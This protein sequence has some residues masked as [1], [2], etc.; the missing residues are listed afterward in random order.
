MYFKMRPRRLDALLSHMPGRVLILFAHPAP[1][2]SRINR[3]LIASVRGL[4]NVTINDLYEEYP[5]FDINVRREQELLL[6]H[7]IIVFQHPFYWYSSPAILKEWEDLVLEY[8]FAY[9][10]GGTKL[11]GKLFLTA[12]TTGG[13]REAYRRAGFNFFTIREL[14]A[15]FEQSAKFCGMRYLPPFVIHGARQFKDESEIIAQVQAYRYVIER[16]RDGIFD[17][18]EIEKFER[19]NEVLSAS[20][21]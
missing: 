18:D 7:D 4:D 9:G 3:R 21:T 5:T 12:I 8:G 6:A 13:P 16:L 2:K 14:L 19:M 20:I 1:H 11:Q 15:P 17:L 10:A